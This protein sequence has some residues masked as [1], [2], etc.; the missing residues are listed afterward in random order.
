MRDVGT[1]ASIRRCTYRYEMIRHDGAQTEHPDP[2]RFDRMLV[3]YT[4]RVLLFADPTVVLR[5]LSRRQLGAT[6]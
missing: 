3:T 6:T 2:A 4:E 5:R 1:A